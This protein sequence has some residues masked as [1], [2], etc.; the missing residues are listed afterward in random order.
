MDIQKDLIEYGKKMVAHGLT[1]NAG[2]NL[3]VRC[4]GGMIITP[5]G[6]DYELI[7][8]E[9]LCRYAEASGDFSGERVPS[10]EW[11]LHA[12]IY[13]KRRDIHAIVHT[14]SP[15]IGVLST[16]RE[17]LPPIHYLIAS[18]GV[19]RVPVAGYATY[20]T[21]ELAQEAVSALGEMARAVILSNHGLIAC[22]KSLEEAYSSARNLEFC[23][24]LYIQALQTGKKPVLL[25]EGEMEEMFEKSKSYGQK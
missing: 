4:D 3:S 22:G 21:R 2:G 13:E 19:S 15:Y 7:E 10:S 16:L 11:Q 9:D 24:F 20:G 23:A 5:S 1:F 14:H 25:T 6:M 12:A 8:S 17:E 18:A